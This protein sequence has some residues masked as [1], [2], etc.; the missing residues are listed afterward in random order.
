MYKN[1]RRLGLC[2]LLVGEH[3]TQFKSIKRTWAQKHPQEIVSRLKEVWLHNIAETCRV[4][5]YCIDNDIWCYRLS[6]DLFGLAD[7]PE[8]KDVWSDFKSNES[9]WTCIR[10]HVATYIQQ[11]GRL[12]THPGQ[13]C[14]ISNDNAIITNRSVLALDHHADFFDAMQIPQNYFFPINIHISN[15]RK[16]QQAADNVMRNMDLLSSSTRSRL[17]FETE[18]KNYWTYQRIQKH[19]PHIPITL[20]YHHRH[21]N[22][23]GEDESLAHDA[24]VES[25]I[26]HNI[27]PLFHYTEGRDHDL[28]RKHA[29]YIK[30]LPAY[31]NVDLEIE[32]KQKNLAILQVSQEST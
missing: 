13:F 21:I 7:L 26:Q 27:K 22:N 6:S 15:G 11:G 4:I 32:A 17:V 24:C 12:S 10:R 19:F 31:D 9:N 29:D 30:H 14:V 20:D 18:D 1:N 28:D 23:L 16:E 25:W 2:C 8:Y 5:N 3:K